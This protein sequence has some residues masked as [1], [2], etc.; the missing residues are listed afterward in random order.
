M[1][2]IED[3]G[4][5]YASILK[6]AKG[7]AYNRPSSHFPEWGGFQNYEQKGYDLRQ[8]GTI[9]FGLAERPRVSKRA[10]AMSLIGQVSTKEYY[11]K[12]TWF[13]TE[14]AGVQTWT[15]ILL[16]TAHATVHFMT[17]TMHAPLQ[18]G[19]SGTSWQSEKTGNEDY[20]LKED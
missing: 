2:V 11:G 19:M 17:A 3:D 14:G 13:Q 5:L 20:R 7:R 15:D 18:F 16:H 8:G 4:A 10:W 12:F 6:A 1:H 9:L